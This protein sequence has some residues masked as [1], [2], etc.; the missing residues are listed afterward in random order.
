MKTWTFEG[1]EVVGV[2]RGWVERWESVD[3]WGSEGMEMGVNVVCE[4]T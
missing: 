4:W 3:G 2:K 1:V